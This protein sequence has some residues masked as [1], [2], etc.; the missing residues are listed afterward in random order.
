MSSDTTPPTDIALHSHIMEPPKRFTRRTT[1]KRKS[2]LPTTSDT[3]MDDGDLQFKMDEVQFLINNW[4]QEVVKSMNTPPYVPTICGT[5]DE[6]L[7]A[8]RGRTR[9][10]VIPWHEKRQGTGT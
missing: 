10:T 4:E 7:N 9:F 3:R 8:K 5:N 6:I 2:D 1:P